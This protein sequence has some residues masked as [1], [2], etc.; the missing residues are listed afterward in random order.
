[1]RFRRRILWPPGQDDLGHTDV[2]YAESFIDI[3]RGSSGTASPSREVINDR[4]GELV[5]LFRI[6]Q[7]HY[8]QF[9]D[10]LKFQITRR[11]EFERLKSCHPAILTDLERAARFI[12]LQKLAFGCKVKARTSA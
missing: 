6:L 12:Y 4:N 1:M 9:M 7:R 5:N 10:T 3:G 2:T 8:P 11:R